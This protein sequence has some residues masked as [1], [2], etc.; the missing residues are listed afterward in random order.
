VDRVAEEL[1]SLRR[2]PRLPLPREAA[3]VPMALFLLF[4]AGLLPEARAGGAERAPAFAVAVAPGGEGAPAEA[5]ALPLERLARGEPLAPREAEALREA[6]ERGLRRPEE[7]RAA[8][9]SLD[10]AARGEG[11]AAA[12]VAEALSGRGRRGAAL[13]PTAYPEAEEFVRAYRRALEEGR[14]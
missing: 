3:L 8:L 14:E 4:A 13:L 11:E 7:R 10:R 9:L 5:E 12:E 2:L 1:A 6:I